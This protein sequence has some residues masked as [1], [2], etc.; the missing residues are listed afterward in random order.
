M[1]SF[2]LAS[3][4]LD[5]QQNSD[6]LARYRA[7]YALFPRSDHILAQTATAHYNLRDFDEAEGLFEELL[8]SDPYR[9]EGF[10]HLTPFHMIRKSILLVWVTV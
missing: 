10:F 6:A 5:L 7:L 4:Y 9:L 2:F 3:V 1:R 8:R